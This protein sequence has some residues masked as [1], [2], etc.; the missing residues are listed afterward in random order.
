MAEFKATNAAS[1]GIKIDK[2][3]LKALSRR[4]NKPGLIYLTQWAAFLCVTGYLIWVTM[5]TWWVW[6]AM[7]AHGIF[8]TVPAYA[9]SH[10]TAHGTA[11]KTRWLNEAVLW[12]TSFIYFEEPLH[13]RYTH[14]NHHTYTWHVGKDS[15]MPFDT[16][17]AFGGWV[18]EITGLGLARFHIH[19]LFALAMNRP[20]ELTASTIPD[21]ELPKLVRNARIFILLCIGVIALIA[22][23]YT[24][25]IWFLIIP[26]LLGAPVMLLFT[27]IQHVE[28]QEDSSSI[29]DSTRSFKTNW[30]G[31]F[32]Y[33]NMNNH[34]E[35]HL[36]PQVPFYSLHKLHEEIRDQLPEPD[37]GFF[38][39]NLEVILVVA[40]RT[41]GK[42]T[43]APTIR[44]APHMI[45]DGG[46]VENIAQRS[47]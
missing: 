1:S 30:L 19:S 47:M 6:P 21:G 14:T 25:P 2:K 8:L 12:V 10:E 13:R 42:A 7:L 24:W 15:Q 36:Y 37:P 23:G 28:M 45:T 29:L 33:A 5:G 22:Y 17:M 39:T 27:L 40:R 11:F 35:H 34:V 4:S 18:A 43:K 20:S 3:R 32:L 26:R 44:Q 31:R 9:I 38:R 46:P 41:M 16:P